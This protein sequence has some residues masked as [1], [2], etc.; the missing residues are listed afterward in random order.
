MLAFLNRDESVKVWEILLLVIVCLAGGWLW[1]YH[2]EKPTTVKEGAAAAIMQKDHSVV[3]ERTPAAQAPTAALKLPDTPKGSTPIRKIDVTIQPTGHLVL[4]P[5][6]LP[7]PADEA[8]PAAASGPAI[9]S[10]DQ[11]VVLTNKQFVPP[12]QADCERYYMC[13]AVTTSVTIVRMS[14][15]TKRAIASTQDGTVVGGTDIPLEDDTVPK[16]HD[17]AAGGV[18][19][20]HQRYGLFIDHDV[21]HFPLLRVGGEV[22]HDPT[23]GWQA[24]GKIGLRW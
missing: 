19:G 7:A 24:T 20:T 17:W 6:P 14:D 1:G 16:E 23:T 22:L 13:P 8:A 12:S 3:L 11:S 18:I 21:K 2:W 15:G 10:G 9:A 4:R 5:V